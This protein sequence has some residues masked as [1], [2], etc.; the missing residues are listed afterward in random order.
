ML[1]LDFKFLLFDSDYVLFIFLLPASAQ[2]ISVLFLLPVLSVRFHV[3]D[4]SLV[5]IG[6]S[7]KIVRLVIMSFS[8]TTW[9][10]FM[11]VIIGKVM[12]FKNIF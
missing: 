12:R 8:T 7:F 2:G 3:T 9:M 5:L 1:I 11:S 4:T 10:V 6:L